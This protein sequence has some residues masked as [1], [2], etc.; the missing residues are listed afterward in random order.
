[1]LEHVVES[2]HDILVSDSESLSS[3]ESNQE[4]CHPSRECLIAEI[5]EVEAPLARVGEE[6]PVDVLA[7]VANR[8]A[9]PPSSV[10]GS[11]LPA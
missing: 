4:S 2:I 5:Q 1:M 7:R 10:V 8:I 11:A 3:S 9:T 6:R